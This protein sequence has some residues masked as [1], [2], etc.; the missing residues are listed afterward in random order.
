FSESVFRNVRFENTTLNELTLDATV[1]LSC[2]LDHV[3]AKEA[4]LNKCAFYEC[5]FTDSAFADSWL[6]RCA[7]AL[8]ELSGM[9]FAGSVMSAF[10]LIAEKPMVDCD[11]SHARISDGSIRG[12]HFQ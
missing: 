8:C 9:S 3:A 7:F 2:S 10:T 5:I 4:R 11:F 1:M 12:V 6:I